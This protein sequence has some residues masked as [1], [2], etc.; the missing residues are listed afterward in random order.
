MLIGT[1][2]FG[3]RIEFGKNLW[4]LKNRS[5]LENLVFDELVHFGGIFV[6]HFIKITKWVN[7][8]TII[9]HTK[10]VV[11]CYLHVLITLLKY[12]VITFFIDTVIQANQ[13]L[14]N[15]E[16]NE[17]ITQLNTLETFYLII[18]KHGSITWP[19]HVSRSHDPQHFIPNSTQWRSILSILTWSVEWLFKVKLI[20]W[21]AGLIRLHSWIWTGL[22]L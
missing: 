8:N 10:I 16:F 6:V 21:S 11:F 14:S 3:I 20:I 17:T 12:Y 9:V 18:S 19:S 7:L 1:S 2:P 22:E 13:I 15:S 4:P 5:F